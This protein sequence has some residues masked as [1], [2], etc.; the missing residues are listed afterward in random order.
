MGKTVQVFGFPYVVAA[1]RVKE[2]LEGITGQGTVYALEVKPSKG[3][4]RAFA[5]VQFASNRSAEYIILLA[6]QRLYY[7]S[8]YLRAWKIDDL[9]PMPRSYEHNMEHI[10][11][12]F[13][14]QVAENKFS[15][16]WNIAN[17]SVKFGIGMKKMYFILGFSSVNYKLELSRENIW[18][19]VL[20]Q[21]RGQAA[22][23]LLIQ[24]WLL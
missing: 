12:N 17:V 24:V 13:G 16:L 2:F 22:R 15:V 4:R 21:P 19:I 10:V 6:H 8:S 23:F 20:H 11:L 5:R 1:E 14:C 18:Q 9:V 7:G 3:G